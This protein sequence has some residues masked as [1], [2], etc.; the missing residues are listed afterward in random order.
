MKA[1]LHRVYQGVFV[2]LPD[3]GFP[4][5]DCWMTAVTDRRGHMH[6]RPLRIDAN[7]SESE[8]KA[9]A[10]VMISDMNR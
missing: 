5:K 10:R 7:A 8:A 6:E 2:G 4:A 1:R 9:E 3:S